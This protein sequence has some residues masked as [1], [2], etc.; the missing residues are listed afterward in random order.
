MKENREDSPERNGYPYVPLPRNA[1]TRLLLIPFLVYL[2]WVLETFLFEGNVHLFLHPE[3]AG[4]LIYT[5]VTCILVGLAVP[6]VLMRRTFMSGAVNMFQFGFRSLRRTALAV[7][8]TFLVVCAAVALQNPFG[9]D[10]SAFAA[11]FLLI[12][13]TGAASVMICWVLVGTHVQALVRNGGAL[14]SIS[15]GVVVT[16][17]L[18][19]LT[20]LVQFPG[21]GSQDTLFW[22]IFAGIITAIFFFSV[23]DVWAACVAVTGV[24]V[25]L[26]AGRFDTV[27][28]HQAFPCISLSAVITM[29]ILAVIHWYLSRN[30]VTIPVLS[31]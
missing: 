12:L 21:G 8:L 20:S 3:P 25:Y 24:L 16:A 22:Y 31:A 28:L 15:A 14:M 19:G 1:I 10:R 29:G 23:R 11:A 26:L 4:L 9:T 6:V 18:F 2:I 13:P 30:Y 17:I 5:L 7:A 27:I